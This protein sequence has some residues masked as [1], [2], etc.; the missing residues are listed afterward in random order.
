M[1]AA[2]SGEACCL[3]GFA[4]TCPIS[5]TSFGKRSIPLIDLFEFVKRPQVPAAIG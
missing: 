3:F 2:L 5:D 1:A 4:L